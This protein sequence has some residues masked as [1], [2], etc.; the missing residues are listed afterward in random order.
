MAGSRIYVPI[1]DEDRAELERLRTK[2]QGVTEAAVSR[3][4]LHYGIK[5]GPEAIAEALRED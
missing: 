2:L 4:L 1:S 5:H 3:I